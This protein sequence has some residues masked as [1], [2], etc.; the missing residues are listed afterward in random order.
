MPRGSCARSSSDPQAARRRGERAA[1]D[2]RASHSPEAAGRF[3]VERLRRILTS[4]QWHSA[5]RTGPLY[6]DWVDDLIRSG[7][8]PPPAGLRFE[9]GRRAARKGLL[10][11]L[12]PLAVHER[13]IDSELLSAIEKL[14]GNL[15]SL[16]V[17]HSAALRQ[18]D[19]M[20]RQLQQLRA[21]EATETGDGEDQPAEQRN[22]RS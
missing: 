4:P 5:Q 18:I 17:A 15:Q 3:I 6:T 1:A 10:R 16:A 11:L 8:I 19:E 9:S 22:G 13:M 21:A 14:D 12:K 7:P 2:I 20:D